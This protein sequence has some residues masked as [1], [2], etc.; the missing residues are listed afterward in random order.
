MQAVDAVHD[1]GRCGTFLRVSLDVCIGPSPGAVVDGSHFVSLIDGCHRS[2]A[3][4]FWGAPTVLCRFSDGEGSFDHAHVSFF[5]E[6]LFDLSNELLCRAIVVP[7]H[8][9]RK[10]VLSGIFTLEFGLGRPDPRANQSG[11]RDNQWGLPP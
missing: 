7:A 3:E 10:K 4:F 6:G 8:R 1:S 9:G 5:P 2:R 11:F